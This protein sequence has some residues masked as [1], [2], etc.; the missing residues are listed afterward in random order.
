MNIIRRV[1]DTILF[2]SFCFLVG[3]GIM[4][5]FSFVK[6]MGP[7][8]VMGLGKGSWEVLHLWVGVLMFAAVLVHLFVNRAWIFKVGAKNKTWAAAI[9]IIIGLATIAVLA[10]CPTVVAKV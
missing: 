4:M 6:G 1:V 2:L 10:L 5:K 9:V 7:Q 8:S 3:T